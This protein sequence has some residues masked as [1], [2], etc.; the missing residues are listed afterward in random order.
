MPAALC[1]T[2]SILTNTS[3]GAQERLKEKNGLTLLCQAILLPLGNYSFKQVR[4]VVALFL[5]TKQ[6]GILSNSF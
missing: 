3:L 5:Q 1:C 6:L 2:A 4:A